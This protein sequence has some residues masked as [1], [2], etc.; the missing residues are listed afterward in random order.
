MSDACKV[1]VRTADVV[2]RRF[3]GVGFHVSHHLHEVGREH[4]E[5]VIAKRWREL[6][7]SFARLTHVQGTG[8]EGLDTL[9]EHLLRMKQTGTEVYLAT[10]DPEDVP[11]G[12]ARAAYAKRIVDQLEYLVRERGATNVRHYCMTNELSLHG[13]A[14]MLDDMPKFRDYHRCLFDELEARKL[15]V[16]LLAS[17]ASPIEHWDTIEWAAQHMD[18]VTAIYGGHHYVNSFALEDPEFYP[19]FLSKLRWG[20]G[21]ARS[22]GK[23]FILGEFGCKQDGSVRDGV[24]MDVCIYFG[25]PQEPMVGVQMA[26]AVIAALNA[27]IC[28]LGNWTFTDYPDEYRADYVNK[29][30]TFRW[31][32]DDYSTRA[33]YY[34]YG[35]LT[36][37]FRGPATVFGVDT[38][39]P[40]VRA[41][42]VRHHE[43]G[44]W[45][46]VLLNRRQ[47]DVGIELCI[48]DGVPD[49]PFRKYVYDPQAVPF[50]PFGDLQQPE[51]RL[52][53]ENGRLRDEL[54]AGTLVVYTTSYHE[55]APCPVRGLTVEADAEGGNLLTWQANPE[56]DL[57]YYR[58]HRSAEPGLTPSVTNQIGTTVAT[59]FAD[60]QPPQ[61][62]YKVVAVDSSGNAS[63]A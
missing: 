24:K 32:G 18:D 19:W 54:P 37:F 27:G 14:D 30:G 61:C 21:I 56:P 58:I 10:W 29:W 35:L 45:S 63:R 59:D 6:S 11:E 42:A 53:L 51:A 1:T 60:R 25:T 46:I 22:R 20:S 49:A 34:A 57:C 3:A 13:W 26:E 44:T 41:A 48:D 2:Q 50:H 5:H 4:F 39:D 12:P 33:H 16:Q 23:D 8:P 17:D 31:I 7:P 15:D 43:G 62:Q 47:D 9:A 38:G 55:Q 36:R 52:A 28:A 40:L